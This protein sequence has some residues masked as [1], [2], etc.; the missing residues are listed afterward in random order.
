MAMK[1]EIT[2]VLGCLVV[3]LILMSVISVFIPEVNAA[4]PPYYCIGTVI[5]K[6]IQNNTITIQ[7]DYVTWTPRSCIVEG[8]VPN[9]DA[10]NEIEIGDYVEAVGYGG[11]GAWLALG[12]M[13]S[14]TEK[15]ISAVYGDIRRLGWYLPLLGDYDIRY[16]NTP[17][18]PVYCGGLGGDICPAEY[19]NITITKADSQVDYHQLY[20]SQSYMYEGEDHQIDIT[21]LSGEASTYPECIDVPPRGMPGPDPGPIS[22]FVIHITS[23]TGTIEFSSDIGI[24]LFPYPKIF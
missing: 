19:T 17:D 3:F 10:L 8:T 23:T 20:P 14:S 18:C 21:F 1:K 4:L 5:G 9:K 12:K 7:T 16:S 11:P 24:T 2:K 13:K 22:N 15:V 6:D